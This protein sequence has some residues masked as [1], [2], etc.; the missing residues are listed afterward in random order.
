VEI[1]QHNKEIDQ[2]LNKKY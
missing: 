2:N 1:K